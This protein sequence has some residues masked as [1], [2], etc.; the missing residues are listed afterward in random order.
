M[1]SA[2]VVSARSPSLHNAPITDTLI[3]ALRLSR[4]ETVANVYTDGPE[5]DLDDI[6]D[7]DDAYY[8]EDEEEDDYL[9]SYD[10]VGELFD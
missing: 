7:Y 2:S 10:G 4:E 8:T 6:F 5:D 9:A 3:R 1:T